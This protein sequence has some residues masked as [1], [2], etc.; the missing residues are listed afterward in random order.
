MSGPK[1]WGITLEPAGAWTL[2]PVLGSTGQQRALQSDQ[3]ATG[4]YH[5]TEAADK[6]VVDRLSEIA[7]TRELPLVRVALAWLL[8]K[9]AVTAPIVGATKPHHL[10]DAVGA[11]SVKLSDE[12]VRAL[13]EPYIPHPLVGF[14]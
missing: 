6:A 12:E 13:E 10:E 9:P 8:Q 11:L 1:D 2:N 7:K 3:Y 5:A 4:L 14:E